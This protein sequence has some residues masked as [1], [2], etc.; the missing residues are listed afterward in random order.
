MNADN[1]I[2]SPGGDDSRWVELVTEQVR[3]LSYGMVEIVVHDSRVIQVEKTER[4][5]LEKIKK[6]EFF[7]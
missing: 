6:T 4:L 2:S 1:Q 7:D 3:S 5:R